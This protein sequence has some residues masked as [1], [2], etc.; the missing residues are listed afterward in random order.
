[1]KNAI[2]HGA[3]EVELLEVLKVVSVLG[4][5]TCAVGIPVLDEEM[6][7]LRNQ[8]KEMTLNHE[9]EK[10]KEKFIDKM[11]YWNSFWIPS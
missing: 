8:P 9:Q 2:K 3:T 7:N 6:V 5:H 1:M 4:M 10:L 11:G